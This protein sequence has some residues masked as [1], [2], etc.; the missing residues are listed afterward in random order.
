MNIHQIHYNIYTQITSNT[1]INKLGV[2]TEINQF[3]F[4]ATNIFSII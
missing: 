2:Q 1:S 3:Y 4:R